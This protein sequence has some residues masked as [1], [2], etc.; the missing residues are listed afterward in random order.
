MTT[1]QIT[2]ATN[3]A[4]NIV[5]N[6]NFIAIEKE[7][8][9][10]TTA[11]AQLAPTDGSIEEEKVN[12]IETIVDEKQEKLVF[13]PVSGDDVGVNAWC[14]GVVSV[15]DTHHSE[16]Q[17]EEEMKN[18]EKFF[19]TNI[20][21]TCAHTHII[22]TAKE[23]RHDFPYFHRLHDDVVDELTV[24]C[25]DWKMKNESLQTSMDQR[26]EEEEYNDG[27]KRHIDDGWFRCLFV[28]VWVC[29]P[30]LLLPQTFGVILYSLSLSGHL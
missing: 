11:T 7:N 27:E 28:W 22:Y 18:R 10:I 19:Y 4:T 26:E 20:F 23:Q 2:M 14:G 15:L 17:E 6:Q 29:Q 3:T 30:V 25:N 21:S 13:K 8:C 9:A 12:T 16:I 5:D 1:P 24:R